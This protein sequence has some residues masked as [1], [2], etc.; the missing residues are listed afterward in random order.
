[1]GD[2][3]INLSDI[4]DG[5][6]VDPSSLPTG[7]E[8]RFVLIAGCPCAGKTYVRRQQYSRGFVVLDAADIFLRFP[9]AL[10]LPFPGP[11]EEGL[12]IIGSLISERAVKERRAIVTEMVGTDDYGESIS[13]LITGMT[14]IGYRAEIVW[15]DAELDICLEREK[16]RGKEDISSYYTERYH[17]KWLLNAVVANAA[18]SR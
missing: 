15:V 18:P 12:E 7:A 4:F 10:D 17:Q 8:P 13:A 5:F 3:N 9:N 6:F 2:T 16:N 11:Y 14:S 1:M